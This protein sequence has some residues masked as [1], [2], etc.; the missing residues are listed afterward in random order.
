VKVNVNPSPPLALVR[1]NLRT[2]RER[3]GSGIERILRALEKEKLLA[4]LGKKLGIKLGKKPG[5]KPGRK[6]WP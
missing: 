1:Q 2:I 4:K 3:Y 5:K 6:S